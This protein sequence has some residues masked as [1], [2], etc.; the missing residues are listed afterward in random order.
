[1]RCPPDPIP[2]MAECLKPNSVPRAASGQQ[3]VLWT[4]KKLFVGIQQDTE[5]HHFRD[6]F[7]KY[8]KMVPLRS[9]LIG[10]LARGSGFMTFDDLDSVDKTV[11][12]KNYT[13]S[14]HNAEVA[15]ALLTWE[16]QQV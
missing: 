10:S 2:L 3:G 15:K 8:G 5:E 13:I 6:Y 7:E 16:M 9:L 1:M 14:G 11:L 12:P 4:L